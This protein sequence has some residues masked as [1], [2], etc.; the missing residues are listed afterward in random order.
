MVYTPTQKYVAMYK[1]SRSPLHNDIS[2]TSVFGLFVIIINYVCCFRGKKI[3]DIAT[4]AHN[5]AAN[6]G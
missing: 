4:C 2:F 3:F 1:C 5:A 6:T